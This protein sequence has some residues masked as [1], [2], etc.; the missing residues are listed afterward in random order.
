MRWI[1]D[2]AGRRWSAERVGR[3]S[4]LVSTKHRPA[5]FPEPADIDPSDK[6]GRYGDI[7]ERL[8]AT[9]VEDPPRPGFPQMPTL[10]S[11]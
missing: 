3:T 9:G 7:F 10:S 6:T 8:T 1:F 2:D 4:G 11:E 5:G